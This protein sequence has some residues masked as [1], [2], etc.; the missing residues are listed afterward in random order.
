MSM[1]ASDRSKTFAHMKRYLGIKTILIK[2]SQEQGHGLHVLT[3]N[4]LT[5]KKMLVEPG[6]AVYQLP[7]G[8]TVE[9]YGAGAS[10]PP[11]LFA[12]GDVV[13]GYRVN[14]IKLAI[15]QLTAQGGRLLSDVVTICTTSCY[16]FMLVSGSQVVGLYQLSSCKEN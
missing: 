7:D 3:E 5:A 4:L 10:Y 9:L 8:T 16:C 15:E 6:L 14:D 13:I 11:Y 1:A 12:H 2:V